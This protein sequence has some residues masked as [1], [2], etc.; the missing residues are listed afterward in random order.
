MV[1]D[2]KFE[3]DAQ[4]LELLPAGTIKV[5]LSEEFGW[6]EVRCKKSGKMKKNNVSVLPSDWVKVEISPYDMT[7]WRIVYRYNAKPSKKDI[8]KIEE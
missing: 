5:I 1:N 3:V 8:E 7:Q 6:N 4:V 2:N